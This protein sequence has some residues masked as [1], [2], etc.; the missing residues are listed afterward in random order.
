MPDT[1]AHL[2]LPFIMAA[3]AQKHVTHNE[4]LRLL[5]GIVQLSVITRGLT[6]PPATPSEGDRYIPA[7][8]AT[9]A[10]AG[11]D[12]SIAYWIDGAWMKI[13]PAPGWL[14]WAVDEAQA[15]VWTGTAWVPMASAMGF[16][17]QSA[18][19]AVARGTN[20]ATTG[21]A[22][23]EETLSGLSGASRNST[24]VIPDRAI[25]LGVSCRVVTAITG[26]AS[27]DCGIAG[28]TSKFGGSLGVSPG[29]SNIGVVG[30]QAFYAATP[31]RLTANGGS[32]TGGAVRIA[33]HYL[34]CGAPA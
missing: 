1:T 17:A 34:T 13:L 24:I 4:A 7:T 23:A 30:P 5:D 31:I 20:N 33:I 18:N 16:I 28:E 6:D 15:I 10:W 9:G 14:A 21:I 27:F 11:W 2:A 25:V 8:G 19:V 29:S 3:Q 26:A 12:G 32:F 22:V